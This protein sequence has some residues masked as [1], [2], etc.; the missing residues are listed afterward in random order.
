[1]KL[2][3]LS[4][5][6][7]LRN[8]ISRIITVACRFGISS[9]KFERC[10]KRYFDVTHSAG[11]IPTFALTAVVLARHPGYIKELSYRGVEFAVHGY[12]HI[13]YKVVDNEKMGHHFE[14]AMHTFNR[15]QVPFVG[16]RAPFLR[17]N[18]HTT[19]ILSDLGFLYDSSRAL[20]WPVNDIDSYSTYVKDNLSLL[21]E[22]YQPLDAEKYL[23]LPRFED[24]LIEIPVSIP[25]DEVLVERMG[26]TDSE[27]I[28]D[29]WVEIMQRIYDSGELFNFSLHPERIIHCENGLVKILRKAREL[30]PPV[31]IATLREIAEWWR[32]RDKFTFKIE[33]RSDGRYG[34][35][36]EC[37]ERA[38]ILLK[39]G[40]VNVS[41][42]RWL[43]SYLYIRDRDF[44]LESPVRPVIGIA[45]GS[46]T[47]AVKFLQSEGYIVEFNKKPEECGIYLDDLKK[48]NQADE[49][50]LSK[51][52][53]QS[54]AYLLR[55][56]RWPD[57][58]R[59]ALSITGDIDSITI[60]D[61]IMRI[62]ESKF[63]S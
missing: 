38:T 34:V 45:A 18:E 63:K 7:G 31:W 29:I 59:S 40:K 56:W 51:K 5:S 57:G 50:A 11:C 42:D 12:V 30:N 41:A 62:L 55:Y 9:K 8:L 4:K 1:M 27:K 48:F 19:P 61:F 43:D 47:T 26:I 10:L 3:F 46:S 20:W 60:T 28:S 17:T 53:E 2:S 58:A 37:S 15:C 54:N 24:G 13:D 32:E 52:I 25:D 23:S 16:F 44:S 36:A 35:K 21:K 33:H 22:F 39:N 14:R 49:K 6:R